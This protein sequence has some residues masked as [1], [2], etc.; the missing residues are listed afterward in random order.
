VN[1]VTNK[2]A[3]RAILGELDVF[4]MSS[5]GGRRLV[6]MSSEV[7]RY[8]L[9]CLGKLAQKLL[10]VFGVSGLEGR[11]DYANRA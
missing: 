6:M 2:A 4:D 5:H 10:E 8:R 9:R 1:Y 11:M 7:L 3:W